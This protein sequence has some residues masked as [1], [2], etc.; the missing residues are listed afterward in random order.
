[1]NSKVSWTVSSFSPGKPTMKLVWARIPTWR[2]TG[3]ALR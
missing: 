2:K 3:R 1:M